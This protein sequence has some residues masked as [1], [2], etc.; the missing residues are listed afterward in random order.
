M[1]DA[2]LANEGFYKLCHLQEMLII[3]SVSPRIV[4]VIDLWMTL[5]AAFWARPEW[6]HWFEEY[7]RREKQKQFSEPFKYLKNY[8]TEE[9]PEKP[10]N[11]PCHGSQ[12]IQQ[13]CNASWEPNSQAKAWKTIRKNGDC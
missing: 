7:Y 12:A 2:H 6:L 4:V 8:N 9:T 10:L 13:L 1:L 5:V 3:S 11:A